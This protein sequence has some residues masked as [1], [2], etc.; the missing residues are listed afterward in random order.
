MTTNQQLNPLLISLIS[1]FD[2][3]VASYEDLA[4]S[5]LLTIHME[6]RANIIL[7][8][9]K[10][11]RNNFLLEQRINEPDPDILNLNADLVSFDEVITTYLRPQ[12]HKFVIHS[13]VSLNKTHR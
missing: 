13:K 1:A 7:N 6:I 12:E 3:I 10:S 2:S 5:V 4:T 8:V 11:L 9:T